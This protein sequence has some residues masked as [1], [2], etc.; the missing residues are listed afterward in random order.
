MSFRRQVGTA[1]FIVLLMVAIQAGE[2][3]AFE[4]KP[5]DATY[6][7]NYGQRSFTQRRVSDGKGRMR[8]ELDT[9][10]GKMVNIIDKPGKTS[11]T[12]IE[13]RKMAMKRS[14]D[15]LGTDKE[16]NFVVADD[17]S[18]SEVGAKSIG[19]KLIDGHSCH[20]YRYTNRGKVSEAWI[21]DDIGTL[22]LMTSDSPEGKVTMRLVSYKPY[23]GESAW[24]KPP[25]DYKVVAMPSFGRLKQGGLGQLMQSQAQSG[26][27]DNGAQNDMSKGAEQT[28]GF[29]INSLSKGAMTP[30]KMQRLKNFAEQM[31][32]QYGG[33]NKGAN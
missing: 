17:K 33:V 6:E 27:A 22:V 24:F 13:S 28:P 18:A 30:E 2:V 8:S 23:D 1:I 32:Q 20:G 25:H 21:G 29:N 3:F 7:M 9:K 10:D 19:K 26:G 16:K 12:I 31:K 14:I 4:L 5:Y 15:G 11:Y